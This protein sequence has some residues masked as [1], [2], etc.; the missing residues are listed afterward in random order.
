M[1]VSPYTPLPY[2]YSAH[3][4][5]GARVWAA[6]QHMAVAMGVRPMR[7]VGS[8]WNAATGMRDEPYPPTRSRL[9]ALK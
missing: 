9:S 1:H 4:S 6:A 5:W 7:E 2:P 8:P 3:A